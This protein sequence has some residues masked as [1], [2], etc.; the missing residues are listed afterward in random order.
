MILFLG[1]TTERIEIICRSI[2][3]VKYYVCVSNPELDCGWEYG[4]KIKII[5]MPIGMSSLLE[6]RHEICL[7]FFGFF[8][9]FGTVVSF[10]QT[11]WYLYPSSVSHHV[12]E[13]E[14]QQQ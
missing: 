2:L 4:Q 11:V 1:P 7:H 6:N 13:E 9:F 10:H 8:I 3:Y 5:R 12:H 14:D